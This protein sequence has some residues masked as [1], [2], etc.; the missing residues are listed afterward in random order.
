M[1]KFS[2]I[3][4]LTLCLALAQTGCSGVYAV[5]PGPGYCGPSYPPA[6]WG[7]GGFYGGACYNGWRGGPASWG[8]GSGHASGWRG[9]SASWG[10]GSGSWHGAGGGSGSWHG[11]GGRGR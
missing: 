8:G 9:G 4:L 5:G 6:Y 3:A 10:G 7:G 1:M 2:L 11:G